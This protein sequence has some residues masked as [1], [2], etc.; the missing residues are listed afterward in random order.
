HLPAVL[1]QPVHGE[2][3]DLRLLAGRHRL[4]PAAEAIRRTALHLA[5]HHRRAVGVLAHEV[6]LTLRA[7]P[8]AVE[9]AVALLL[10]PPRRPLLP[11]PASGLAGRGHPSSPVSS[12]WEGSSSM[13][14]SLKV[15]ML[16]ELTKRFWRYM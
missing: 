13:F 7:P 3:A 6:E 2:R 10:V 8:V 14:T 1:A 15:R 11:R 4:E 5:E 16:T 12:S 9:H